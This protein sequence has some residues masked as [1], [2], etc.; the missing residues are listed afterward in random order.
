MINRKIPL[1]L[2]VTA[3]LWGCRV[4]DVATEPETPGDTY[5]SVTIRLRTV[6]PEGKEKT[7]ILLSY[8]DRGDRLIF[9]SP[10]NQVL[11]EIRVTGNLSTVIVPRRNQFWTGEFSEFFSRFRD[12]DLTYNEIKALLLEQ[13]Y[14]GKRLRHL[15][16]SIRIIESQREQYPVKIHLT[17]DDMQLEFRVYEQ[18]RKPGKLNLTTDLSGY[19]KVPLENLMEDR[20]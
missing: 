6:T 15:G 18:V 16:F 10:L 8:N 14:D 2:M 13:R 1:I 17:R 12:M 5:R 3:M 11:F 7:K 4:P 9:L 19:R 20:N